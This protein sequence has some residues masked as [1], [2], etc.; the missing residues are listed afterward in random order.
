MIIQKMVIEVLLK[1]ASMSI[2]SD[3]PKRQISQQTAF[4]SGC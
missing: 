4:F 1:C 3:V 2:D